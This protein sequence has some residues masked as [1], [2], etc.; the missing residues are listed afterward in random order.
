MTGGI[1]FVCVF[2]LLALETTWLSVKNTLA[3][4][5]KGIFDGYYPG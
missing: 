4:M 1:L 5:V 2:V 3:I